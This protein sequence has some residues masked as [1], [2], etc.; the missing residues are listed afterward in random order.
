MQ[1]SVVAACAMVDVD[2]DST[3]RSGI[4][5]GRWTDEKIEKRDWLF[6]SRIMTASKI[7]G[8]TYYLLQ[9]GDN[10]CYSSLT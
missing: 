7:L 3:R 5:G 9:G 2:V 4:S 1:S 10:N 8:E 6:D